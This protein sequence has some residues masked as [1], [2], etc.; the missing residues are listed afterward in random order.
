[1]FGKGADVITEYEQLTDYESLGEVNL[2]DM[3]NLPFYI[4]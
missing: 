3:G 1:M 2:I 4:I